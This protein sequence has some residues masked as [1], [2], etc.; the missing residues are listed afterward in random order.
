MD[1]A[2]IAKVQSFGFDVWMHGP[3]ES[4]S[5]MIFTD[6]EGKRL[7]Y[8]QENSGGIGGGWTLS[9][10]HKPNTTTGTGY[11]MGNAVADFTAEDLAAC[12][13]MGPAWALNRDMASVKKYRDMEEYRSR[14]SWE[15]KYRKLEPVDG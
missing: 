8:L 11:S 13:A 1:K 4:A 15:A 12:F 2:T 10:V 7:G 5:W 3:D 9:T 6:P 14:G